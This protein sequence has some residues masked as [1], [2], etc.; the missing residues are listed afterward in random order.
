MTEIK[1]QN[2]VR[3][4]KNTNGSAILIYRADL[5]ETHKYSIC[6]EQYSGGRLQ[7]AESVDTNITNTESADRLLLEMCMGQLEPCHLKDVIADMDL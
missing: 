1:T 7:C 6:I 3:A 5:T 4:I 2:T